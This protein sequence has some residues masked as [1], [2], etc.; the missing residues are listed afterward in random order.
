M[1]EE[2]KKN[3]LDL[4]YEKYLNISSTSIIIAFTYLIGVVIGI[5][6]NQI[7]LNDFVSMSSLFI[8]SVVVLGLCATFFFIALFHLTNIPK[9]IK[10]L[11]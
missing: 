11:Q 1:K 6:S 4:Q 5:F 10:N 9:V 8:V 2:I 3:I 7:K